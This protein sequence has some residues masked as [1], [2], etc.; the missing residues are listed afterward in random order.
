MQSVTGDLGQGSLQKN[1][2]HYASEYLVNKREENPLLGEAQQMEPG[3]E[4]G[5]EMNSRH[6]CAL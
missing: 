5:L 6:K 4:K 3:E 1:M 2:H